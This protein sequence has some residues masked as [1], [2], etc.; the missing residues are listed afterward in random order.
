MKKLL[1]ATVAILPCLF[2]SLFIITFAQTKGW[3]GIV[4]LHSTR[5]D[6]E[7]LLG[8]PVDSSNEYT[9][10]YHLVNEAVIFNYEGDRPCET[11]GGWQVP[12]ATVVNILVTPKTK[13]RFSDLQVDEK[14][15][16]K[17][18]GG[19]RPEDIIYTDSEAGESITVYQGEV[20]SINYFPAASNNHLRCPE[21][22][23]ALN[24][25]RGSTVYQTLDTY[26]NVPF[27]AEKAVLDNFAIS[28][29]EAPEKEG[30][31]IAYAGR[32]GRDAEAHERAER[33]K[34][35]LVGERGIKPERIVTIDGGHREEF[36][37]EL[38]IVPRQAPAPI[39]TPAIAPR[40]MRIIRDGSSGSRSDRSVRPC[41]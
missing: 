6:V 3:R 21:A 19:H 24:N 8:P 15:Y 41:H 12:P 32:C 14:R 11:P 36:T 38:Y 13:L 33:A 30:Y 7:R 29:L 28:L 27:E 5:A 25:G 16:K 22:R 23:N 40:E 18:S 35:Y 10:V 26:H 37:V 39:P 34:S 17:T 4:P 1:K 2:I 31:L 9:S 20:I